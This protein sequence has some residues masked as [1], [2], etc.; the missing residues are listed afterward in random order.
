MSDINATYTYTSLHENLEKAINDMRYEDFKELTRMM[1]DCY[2]IQ[3]FLNVP[4]MA[5]CCEPYE[6]AQGL[7]YVYH[8]QFIA[9]YCSPV[10]SEIGPFECV[11]EEVSK[12]MEARN[13]S[14]FVQHKNDLKYYQVSDIIKEFETARKYSFRWGYKL[15]PYDHNHAVQYLETFRTACIKDRA[16]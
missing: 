3:G 10:C 12:R 15:L 9:N 5:S 2:E 1:E 4:Y 13:N 7:L 8:P 16:S 14:G 6:I 11:V